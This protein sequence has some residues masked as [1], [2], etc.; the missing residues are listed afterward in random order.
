MASLTRII[1]ALRPTSPRPPPPP[2][3]PPPPPPS[4]PS[5][6]PSSPTTSQPAARPRTRPSPSP[7]P[8]GGGNSTAAASS[9]ATVT[10]TTTTTTN[11]NSNRHRGPASMASAGGTT[12]PTATTANSNYPTA[13]P[14][15]STTTTQLT[16]PTAL[17]PPAGRYNNN[18]NTRLATSTTTTTTQL[19]RPTALLPPPGRYNNNNNTRLATT[20][21]TTTT[22]LSRPTALL[23]PAGRY[24]NNNNTRLATTTTTT[25]TSTTTTQQPARPSAPSTPSPSPRRARPIAQS[26]TTTTQQPSRPSVTPPPPP[27]NATTTSAASPSIHPLQQ[28]FQQQRQR[29]PSENTTYSTN[30]TT[31]T[32]DDDDN[33]DNISS[34]TLSEDDDNS[35]D[36]DDPPPQAAPSPRQ[37]PSPPPSP[38]PSLSLEDRRQALTCSLCLDIFRNPKLLPCSHT[39]CQHCLERLLTSLARNAAQGSSE[40]SLA[41]ATVFSCPNCRRRLMVPPGGVS[42]FQTNFYLHPQ[43]LVKARELTHCLSHPEQGLDMFCVDCQFPV[44]LKCKL[45]RHEDHRTKELMDACREARQQLREDKDRLQGTVSAMIQQSDEARKNMKTQTDMR[46]ALESIIRKHHLTLVGAAEKF[47]VESLACLK[48]TTDEVLGSHHRRVVAT[49]NNLDDLCQL[50][51]EVAS[52]LNTKN[53][54]KLLAAVREMRVGRGSK[55]TLDSI[56]SEGDTDDLSTSDFTTDFLLDHFQ[57][58]LTTVSD[59]ESELKACKDLNVDS[60]VFNVKHIKVTVSVEVQFRC[61]SGPPYT[62]VFSVSPMDDGTV[63]VS[64]VKNPPSQPAPA[65]KYASDGQLLCRNEKMLGKVSLRNIGGGV[66]RCLSAVDGSNRLFCK[67]RKTGHFKLSN[68]VEGRATITKVDVVQEQPFNAQLSELFTINVGPCRGFDVDGGEE[69]FLVLEEPVPPDTTRKVK[70]YLLDNPDPVDTY[71]SPAPLFKPC[72]VCFCR[73]DNDSAVLVADELGDSIHVLKLSAEGHMTFVNYLAAGCPY[74][75]QPTALNVDVQGRLWVA[76]RGGRLL[77]MTPAP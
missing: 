25:T 43:D 69:M 40:T 60:G 33:W 18:N 76:C 55:A 23:P 73:L 71:V 37:P 35:N 44:C 21:T 49:K 75:R 6:N 45:T 20:T 9:S 46:T 56:V 77:A 63:W 11:N 53:R 74:L 16:R 17:L 72:D 19:S 59:V 64:Y 61:G 13:N 47:L 48:S 5:S 12:R 65:E 7:S 8:S 28:P 32:N 50:Q 30:T 26:T 24:N 41:S 66:V 39:F 70:M 38:Q 42:A 68:S 36:H 27:T 10:T 57:Q 2:T 1:A 31:T 52:V 62:E 14:P 15:S 54:Y 58:V 67:L 51:D 34:F 4:Q 22:Q 29:L 3:P